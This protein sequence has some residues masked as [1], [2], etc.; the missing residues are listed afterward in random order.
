MIQSLLQTEV[1]EIVGAEFVT[2]VAGELLILFEKGV[3]PVGA[4]NVMAVL[5]LIDD[6]RQ[7]APEAFVQ[8]HAEDFADPVRG[9]PPKA[10]LAASLEN[11]VNG[12]VAFED[13]VAAILDLRDGVEAATGSSGHVLFWRT[14]APE[15]GSS[16]RVVCG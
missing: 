3:L 14:S 13:E 2:Q 4:K 6:R 8:P 15:S 7:F 5:N 16:S 11:L 10:D 1:S 9:Q 12:E